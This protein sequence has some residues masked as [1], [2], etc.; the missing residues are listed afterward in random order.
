MAK[1]FLRLEDVRAA[2][3][4]SRSAIYEGMA[5][6]TFPKSFPIGRRSVAWASDD[7]EA[8]QTAKLK[9]AGKIQ[10]AA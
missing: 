6:G 8:W 10:E 2:S 9:A 3:G 5:D 1:R 7:I 4:L